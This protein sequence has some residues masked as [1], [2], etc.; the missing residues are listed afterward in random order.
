[1]DQAIHNGIVYY[2]RVVEDSLG[3]RSHSR[4]VV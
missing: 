2:M 3:S 1:M 4:R